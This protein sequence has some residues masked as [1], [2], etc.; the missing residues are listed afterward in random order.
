MFVYESEDEARDGFKDLVEEVGFHCSSFY[1]HKLNVAINHDE[2]AINEWWNNWL[3]GLYADGH[4]PEDA[5]R[6]WTVS[7]D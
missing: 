7:D 3:D 6:S 4:V 5:V 1:T 2:I